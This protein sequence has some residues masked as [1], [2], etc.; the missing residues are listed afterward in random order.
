MKG[1]AKLAAMFAAGLLVTGLLAAVLQQRAMEPVD[2][3]YVP[4]SEA[5]INP[6]G[7]PAEQDPDHRRPSGRS[8]SSAGATEG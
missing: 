4:S 5:T 1:L 3:S 6:H 7:W 2:G 8:R